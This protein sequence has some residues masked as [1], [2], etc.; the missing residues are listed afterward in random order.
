M[1]NVS[2]AGNIVISRQNQDSNVAS[3]S[4]RRKYV[5]ECVAT[6]QPVAQ[7]GEEKFWACSL[8]MLGDR[9]QGWQ[10]STEIRMLVTNISRVEELVCSH[11]ELHGSGPHVQIILPNTSGLQ[12][13]WT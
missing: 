11:T 5:S 6:E 13:H 4:L 10:W 1:G 12:I 2:S 3:S 8:N 9:T 7:Y